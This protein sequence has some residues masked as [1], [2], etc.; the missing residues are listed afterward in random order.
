MSIRKRVNKA[1]DGEALKFFAEADENMFALFADFYQ[2]DP[3]VI[4]SREGTKREHERFYYYK[5]NGSNILAVAHL[6]T[7]QSDR[8]CNIVKTQ[9]DGWFVHSGALDDR[10]G[11]Y[12][13]LDW[14]PTID[15]HMK[16]DWLLTT[17]EE[18]GRSTASD[19]VTNKK[20]NFI[21]EF[22]RKDMDIVT[23]GFGGF[24]GT[25]KKWD[26]TLQEATGVR[27]QRG[28][29][30]DISY[31]EDIGCK[32]ANFG[33]GYKDYHTKRGHAWL[34]D[35]AKMVSKFIQFYRQHGGT[36]FEHEEEVLPSYTTG[37]YGSESY[38]PNTHG[39]WEYTG[40]RYG[41][42]YPKRTWVP[43]KKG[44]D[45]AWAEPIIPDQEPPKLTVVQTSLIDDA[46]IRVA[47]I[48]SPKRRNHNQRDA[49]RIS[50]ILL[51]S[52]ICPECTELLHYG[53]CS[54]CNDVMDRDS[55][56]QR[57]H[58]RATMEGIT[59][60]HGERLG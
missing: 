22:D 39:H 26:E 40:E 31:M 59:A 9:N 32:A 53:Y 12:I 29:V 60:F 33:V 35:T 52:D 41:D 2:L 19:F 4:T 8:S 7:V 3:D 45:G 49:E 21:I 42:G 36:R 56:I 13:I 30:S 55:P 48:I 20:Y 14:L 54:T 15:P 44:P 58:R 34:A 57:R 27:P 11:A 25:G 23:Y 17:D 47:N 18:K 5:D 10:L 6:D 50:S 37:F 1:F 51:D 28:A 38:T 24:R 46:V 43:R 16:F